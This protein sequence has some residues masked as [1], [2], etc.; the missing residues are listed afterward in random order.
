MS[1]HAA[2]TLSISARTACSAVSWLVELMVVLF[3]IGE[4]PWLAGDQAR[5]QL[6]GHECRLGGRIGLVGHRRGRGLRHT[7]ARTD[8]FPADRRSVPGQVRPQTGGVTT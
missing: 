3:S 4:V 2:E 7:G 1:P 8:H 6:A 5:R